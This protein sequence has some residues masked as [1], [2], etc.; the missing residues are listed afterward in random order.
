MKKTLK[1]TLRSPEHTMLRKLLVDA[2]TEAGLTQYQ[3]ADTL[4]WPQSDVSKIE[5]GERRL[6][7]IEFVRLCKVLGND[8]CDIIKKLG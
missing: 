4:Q 2:R 7:V 1:K 3:V 6:D 5:T 8:P